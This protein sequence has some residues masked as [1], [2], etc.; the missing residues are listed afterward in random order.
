MKLS[1][2]PK[3]TK[4]VKKRVG[5]GYGSGR[6]GHAASRGTKGQR[7]RGK[8]GLF[9]EGTKVKKS[10]LKRLPLLRGKGKFKSWKP[11]IAVVNVKYLNLFQEQEEVTLDSLKTRGILAKDLPSDTQVKILGD[12]EITV[13]LVVCLPSSKGAREKIEKAGGVVR[14]SPPSPTLAGSVKPEERK[15]RSEKART[16]E[17]QVEEERKQPANKK[18][19]EK[20]EKSEKRES[21]KVEAK[22]EKKKTKEK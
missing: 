13:P 20:S 21:K 8:I 3:T 6:G 19:T 4:K 2:L 15:K 16:E 10:L 11:P 5:R 17:G 18:M 7:A 22:E 1:E 14:I 12:G 9:F